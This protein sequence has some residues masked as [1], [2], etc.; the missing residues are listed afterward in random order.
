M[1][2]FQT[3]VIFHAEIM[4]ISA[5]DFGRNKVKSGI[6]HHGLVFKYLA[7]IVTTN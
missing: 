3:G 5:V 4:E 2:P 7:I 6:I 1:H